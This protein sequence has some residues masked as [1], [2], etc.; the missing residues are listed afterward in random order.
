MLRMLFA[1]TPM[2]DWFGK[3]SYSQSGE[4]L[5]AFAALGGK[6]RGFYVD[7][8][9]SHPKVFSNTYSF[10]KRGWRGINIEPDREMFEL[11]NWVRNKDV[12]VNVGVGKRGESE[13]YVFEDR[14]A[15]TFD[16]ELKDEYQKKANRN[17]VA[18]RRIKMM[19][20]AD[21]L[22]AYGVSEIDLLSVD[23]E[24]MDVEVLES[25][26]WDKYRPEVIIC[27]DMNFHV[28]YPD[29]SE[30][31]VMLKEKGYQ[32]VGLTP[33]SLVFLATA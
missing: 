20:L 1:A 33:Y 3:R 14:Q 32:M 25:N 7:V 2:Y 10:Y 5:L 31:F 29:G 19:T 17:L 30:V 24:G 9:A 27:E 13:L 26:D 8:G 16:K 4:D 15:N 22:T 6:K 18:T 21:I 12:N 23:T 11:L 28:E